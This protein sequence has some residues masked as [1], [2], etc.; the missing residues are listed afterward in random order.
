MN[1][2]HACDDMDKGLARGTVR[3]DFRFFLSTAEVAMQE[4]IVARLWCDTRIYASK[5]GK[6]SRYVIG[7]MSP[8]W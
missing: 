3:F 2:R 6:V 4:A 5:P 1:K 8:E 7:R